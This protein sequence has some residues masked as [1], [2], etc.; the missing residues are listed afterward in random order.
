[1]DDGSIRVHVKVEIHLHA[2][3]M[4][5]AGHGVP[6]ATFFQLGHAHQELASGEHVGHQKFVNSATV[7]GLR[8]AQGLR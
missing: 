5:V 4:G 3:V 1:M 6:Q 2:P 8:S 7:A